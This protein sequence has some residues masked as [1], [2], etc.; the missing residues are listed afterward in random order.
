MIENMPSVT[1]TRVAITTATANAARK[2]KTATAMMTP[3]RKH[4]GVFFIYIKVIFFS[5]QGH[6]LLFNSPPTE[7]VRVSQ[8]NDDFKL[9][10]ENQS[11]LVDANFSNRP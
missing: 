4:Q 11:F 2:S 8:M 9:S 6:F 1:K 10:K 7:S 3:K 5:C